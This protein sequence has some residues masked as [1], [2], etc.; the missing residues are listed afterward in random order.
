[1]HTFSIGLALQGENLNIVDVITSNEAT[2][3]DNNVSICDT[4]K[5]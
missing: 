4:S 3:L 2:E 1:M 5:Q